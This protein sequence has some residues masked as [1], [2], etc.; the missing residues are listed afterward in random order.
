MKKIKEQAKII[1]IPATIMILIDTPSCIWLAEYVD[2]QAGYKTRLLEAWL[3]WTN[4]YYYFKVI[5]FVKTS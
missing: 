5:P 3:D 2:K 4:S 1:K